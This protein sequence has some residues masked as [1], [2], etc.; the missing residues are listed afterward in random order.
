MYVY[1]VWCTSMSG[2]VHMSGR[3]RACIQCAY[4]FK[5]HKRTCI[6]SYRVCAFIRA[7]MC[8]STLKLLLL[9][10]KPYFFSLSLS[11]S[12]CDLYLLFWVRLTVSHLAK[13][14]TSSPIVNEWVFICVCMM[15]MGLVIGSIMSCTYAI[16]TA[17]SDA[18]YPIQDHVRGKYS[19]LD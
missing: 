13:C 16:T 19:Y 1:F 7:C 9:H 17:S 3:A 12:V 10:T 15:C 2:C 4:V 14:S 11:A 6:D 8:M 5:L 18:A